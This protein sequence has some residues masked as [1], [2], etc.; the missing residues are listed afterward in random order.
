MDQSISSN[1]ENDVYYFKDETINKYFKK[2]KK[3]NVFFSIINLII[4]I[5][6]GRRFKKITSWNRTTKVCWTILKK[7]NK[8]HN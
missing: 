7:S 5:K 1:G 6:I 8:L 4:L 2:K 3:K